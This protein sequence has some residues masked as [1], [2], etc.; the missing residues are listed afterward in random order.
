MIDLL[1]HHAARCARPS[2][3]H[4]PMCL[5]MASSTLIAAT[6]ASLLPAALIRRNMAA[7]NGGEM[8]IHAQ[9]DLIYSSIKGS[10]R[11]AIARPWRRHKSSK[12]YTRNLVDA[13]FVR[14]VCFGRSTRSTGILPAIS[15]ILF[16][17]KR[18]MFQSIAGH[19]FYCT[20]QQFS[21]RRRLASFWRRS[22]FGS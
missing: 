15:T 6:G 8:R 4:L 21:K 19:H 5:W 17:P 11:R 12:I 3:M 22:C 18:E 7:R 13:K 10:L 14:I 1:V 9:R 2:R 16:S 20:F